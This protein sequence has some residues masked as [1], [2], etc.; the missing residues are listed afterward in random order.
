MWRIWCIVVVV[1]VCADQHMACVTYNYLGCVL[2]MEEEAV[3]PTNNNNNNIIIYVWV[4]KSEDVIKYCNRIFGHAIQNWVFLFLCCIDAIMLWAFIHSYKCIIFV[5]TNRRSYNH[6]I[7]T[8][9]MRR[10]YLIVASWVHY[11]VKLY[12][13]LFDDTKMRAI[14]NRMVL[15]YYFIIIKTNIQL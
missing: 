11:T 12:R 3:C 6:R 5:R 2:W 10:R 4:R 15:D 9:V 13:F 14:F 1:V 7:N 8:K